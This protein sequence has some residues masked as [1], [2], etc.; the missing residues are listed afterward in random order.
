LGFEAEFA[1]AAQ[2][3]AVNDPAL[4]HGMAVPG[5]HDY[6]TRGVAASGLFERYF[7]P[8]QHGERLNG[9]VYPFAQRVGP[10]WLIGVNSCTGN[11]WFWDAAGSVGA[12]QLD[13]L[14]QLL[15]RLEPGP[16]ILVTHYPVRLADG[17]AEGAIHRLRD[18]NELMH[19]AREGKISLWLHG[20]RHHA[21]HLADAPIAP[22]PIICVGSATQTGLWSYAEYTIN[23]FRLEARRRVFSL[24]ERRFQD[25][26]TFDL[27]LPE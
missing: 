9:S 5:T 4:P 1:R 24:S 26:E 18:L 7:A 23:G 12:E 19:V 16:R 20:H 15:A 2:L 14:K 21:Y 8:W 11:R 3:M 27:L 6:Y 13:R 17:S 10:V 22:F 25:S